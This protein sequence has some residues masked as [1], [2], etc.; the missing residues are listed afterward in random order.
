[1][2]VVAADANGGGSGVGTLERGPRLQSACGIRTRVSW[3]LSDV[4]RIS[5]F[6]KFGRG[7]AG[8]S[9]QVCQSQAPPGFT[10]APRI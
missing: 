10:L 4:V 9:L 2:A 1:M 8:G 5:S 7:Q 6:P 3:R